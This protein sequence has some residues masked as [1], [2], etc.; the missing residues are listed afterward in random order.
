MRAHVVLRVQSLGPKY[1]QD[2]K[3]G[4]ISVTVVQRDILF[5]DVFALYVPVNQGE[6]RI[7]EI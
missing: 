2:I 7:Q 6:N 4:D 5:L 3:S 1:L